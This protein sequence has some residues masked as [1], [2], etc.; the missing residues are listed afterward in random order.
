MLMVLFLFLLLYTTQL[1]VPL[2]IWIWYVVIAVNIHIGFQLHHLCFTIQLIWSL[3]LS[4]MSHREQ[5]D[6][7]SE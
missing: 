2:K 1:D 3:H 5:Q 4:R 7:P 6:W